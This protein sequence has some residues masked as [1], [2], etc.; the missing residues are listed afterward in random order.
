[1][2]LRDTVR[3]AVATADKV[4]KDLQ[5][6]VTFSKAEGRDGFGEIQ[7]P[8]SV[9]IRAIVD[10]KQKQVRTQDGILSVSRAHVTFLDAKKLFEVTRGEGIDDLDRIVLPDGTTGPVLD[11]DGFID[12]G[13]GI[14][15]ATGVFLG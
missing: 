15:F 2:G 11:M 13:T 9:K 8:T 4:T 10:W 5:P 3:G 1:M 6:E 7:Y 12:A 14:P